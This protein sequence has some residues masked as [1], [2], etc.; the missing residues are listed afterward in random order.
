MAMFTDRDQAGRR[1]AAALADLEIKDAVVLALPRGGVPVAHHVATRLGAP[2]DVLIVRKLGVP[3]HPEYAFGALGEDGVTVIDTDVVRSVHLSE[4]EVTNVVAAETTE[5]SRRVSQYRSGL[6]LTPIAGR[7]ALIIDDGLATGSTMAAAVKVVRQLGAATIVV[8]VPVGSP[9]AVNRIGAMVESIVCLSAPASF[10]AV[11]Q[12]YRDFGQLSDRDVIDVLN[13]HRSENPP[14][15]ASAG[16]DASAAVDRSGNCGAAGTD[17]DVEVMIPVDGAQLGGHLVIPSAATGMVVFAHGSG[18]GRFSPRN[19]YVARSLNQAGLGTLLFDLLTDV[20]SRDRANVF[21][22]PLL[23]SR[24]V[25]ATRWLQSQPE[26]AAC[27]IGYFGASTGAGAALVAAATIPDEV[28]SVVSRGGRPDLAGADLPLVKAPTLLIVGDRDYQ[29]IELNRAAQRRLVCPSRL[30]LVP[31][32][33]HLFEEPG[34]L[35]QAAQLA[36]DHFVRT[37]HPKPP[38]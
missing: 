2:L 33:T 35:E 3:R 30:A 9:D 8:G 27:P 4:S 12:F 5:I 29:V 17:V 13:L 1:L 6:P 18:S 15:I 37:L 36:R 25:G 38:D 24:L 32:A 19:Q 28:S 10:R 7:T 11:G 21:D 16:V 34:T 14:P 26:T 20:E 22:I 23:A 31:G